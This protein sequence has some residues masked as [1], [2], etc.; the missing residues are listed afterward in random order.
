M[1][2]L[3]IY[4]HN[5][6]LQVEFTIDSLETLEVVLKDFESGDAQVFYLPQDEIKALYWFLKDY[7]DGYFQS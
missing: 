6:N 2:T 7:Y 5:S 4:E 3:Q 1:N